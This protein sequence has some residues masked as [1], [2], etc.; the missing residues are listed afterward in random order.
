MLRISMSMV[1][2]LLLWPL[3]LVVLLSI[4]PGYAEALPSL[5]DSIDP[6]LIQ[7]PF[8]PEVVSRWAGGAATVGPEPGTPDGLG[9]AEW[10]TLMTW[11]Y[12]DTASPGWWGD[13]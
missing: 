10:R 12:S 5:M 2:R 4:L 1:R 3:S 9:C 13:G 6:L 8:A 11:L 7:Y